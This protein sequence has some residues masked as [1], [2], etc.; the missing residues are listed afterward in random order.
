[1]KPVNFDRY[2]GS[3]NQESNDIFF[4]HPYIDMNETLCWISIHRKCLQL[5]VIIRVITT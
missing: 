1:M 5:M 3:Q 4:T 2:P